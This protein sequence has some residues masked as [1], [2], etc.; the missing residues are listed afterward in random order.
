MA[1]GSKKKTLKGAAAELNP[2]AGE[3][4]AG[5]E[6]VE[7]TLNFNA[8]KANP[9][10]RTDIKRAIVKIKVFGI[11]GGGNSVLKR[12]AE[13]GFED[14][15]L[16]A[17]N[18]DS[19]AL[20]QMSGGAIKIMQIGENLTKGHGTG[21]NTALGE[22]AAKNDIE[23]LKNTILGA[24]MIFI[25]A[26]M[27]GGTGTGAAP[28]V[29]QIAKE[30]GI[31]TVGVVTV[32]FKFEGSRK[33]KIANEGIIKMQSYMDALITVKN[34]N[35]MKLPEN[36]TLT[37]VDAFRA[38]D[39][40]LK[41]AIRCIAELILTTGFINVDFA[42]VTTIF[43]QSASSDALL[44]I[45]RSNISALKAVQQAFESPLTDKSLKGAR[46]MIL[47][48]T[49]DENLS[50]YEVNEAADYIY[51]QTGDD[52]NLIFGAV[53]DKKMNGV[54]QAMII[55]TDFEDSLALKSPTISVPK[56]RV[57]VSPGFNFSAPKFPDK[58]INENKGGVIPAFSLTRSDDD[59]Q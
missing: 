12:L 10:I 47:N 31:L 46:G 7:G 29:A 48:I 40:V 44:E 26:G 19:H 20:G 42:D 21:G 59:K 34:D 6:K 38:A 56:S 25:T 24:D 8:G 3:K 52:V 51:N 58:K 50:L 33:Q 16:V 15:E 13:G 55:A 57:N 35:L 5:T 22:V 41:Q 23:R 32:P 54:I 17:V 28:V 49:G 30:L 18:T 4:S 45:G 27:G 43:Q 1:M 36:R 9:N 53:I 37:I 39:S 14:T 11:G 2:E